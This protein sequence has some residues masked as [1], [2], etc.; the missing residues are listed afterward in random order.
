MN[1][2]HFVAIS[3]SAA[4]PPARIEGLKVVPL[5]VVNQGFGFGSTIDGCLVTDAQFLSLYLGSGSFSSGATFEPSGR[6]T[7]AGFTTLYAN[8]HEAWSNFAATLGD[9][10]TL[11]RISSQLSWRPSPFPDS[12][13][14]TI[15]LERQAMA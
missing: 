3:A 4:L 10:P 2:R 6:M 11:R 8:S 7:G 9:P 15:W 5:V 12:L 1:R 14:D 13:H